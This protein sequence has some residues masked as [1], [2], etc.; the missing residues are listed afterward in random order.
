MPTM[1][2][3]GGNTTNNIRLANMLA[4]QLDQETFSKLKT[5]FGQAKGKTIL[6]QNR[7]KRYGF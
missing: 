7:A 5:F 6:L 1:I 3:I 4:Q 2:E